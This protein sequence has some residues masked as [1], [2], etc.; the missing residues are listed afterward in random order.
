MRYLFFIMSLLIFAAKLRAEANPTSYIANLGQVPVNNTG[1]AFI[2]PP[3]MG[4]MTD[5]K[6]SPIMQFVLI[7]HVL[8]S[9]I[10][11]TLQN[12]PGRRT[13]Y[14]AAKKQYDEGICKIQKCFQQG[15]VLGLIGQTSDKPKNGGSA[16]PAERQ[17]SANLGLM[18]AMTSQKED[19]GGSGA[20]MDPNMIQMLAKS[21][22]P[23]ANQ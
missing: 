11:A 21:A 13:P 9:C 3:V 12:P 18:F 20:G 16:D 17:S 22:N 1:A 19:C 15:M 7:N 5:G 23:P 4:A 10:K 2:P 6:I 8:D 14:V